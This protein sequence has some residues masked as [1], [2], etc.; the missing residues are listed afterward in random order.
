MRLL[1]LAMALALLAGCGSQPQQPPPDRP[2]LPFHKRGELVKK[3]TM[4]DMAK[5]APPVEITVD[6]PEKGGHRSYR[7]FPMRPLLEDVYGE[8][9][10]EGDL[11]AF[12]L[13]GYKPSM[14]MSRFQQHEAF[15]AFETADGKAFTVP[16]S[17][18]PGEEVAAAPYYLIW[19]N[20]GVPAFEQD[21]GHAW[22]YQIESFDLI[23]YEDRYPALT[24]PPDASEAALR[25]LEAW[26]THCTA[27]HKLNGE[28]GSLGPELNIPA[29]VT[30]YIKEDWLLRWI[31][32]PRG[33]RRGTAMPGLVETL[34]D[35]ERVAADL[36]EYL[37]VMARNKKQD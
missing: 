20:L 27:C 24:P 22:P 15:L 17:E 13:D 1:I 37:K 3:L 10:A 32:D 26:R 23:R 4:E 31:L 11:M 30:E 36:I 18:S 34:P 5:A 16:D 14:P 7:A 2:A 29:S 35:R 8:S 12:C 33:V 21:L 28:G 25:G 9:W 6:V 19:K